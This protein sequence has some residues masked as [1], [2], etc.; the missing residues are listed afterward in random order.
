[1]RCRFA[2]AVVFVLLSLAATPARAQSGFVGAGAAVTAFRFAH[3]ANKSP[4][5][6]DTDISGNTRSWSVTAGA[7]VARRAVLQVEFSRAAELETVIEPVVFV[8][9]CPSCGQ[10]TT[11]ARFRAQELAIL[12]GFTGS[13]APRLSLTALGGVAFSAQRLH[14]LSVHVPLPPSPKPLPSESESSQYLIAPEFGLDAAIALTRHL[15]VVPRV[16]ISRPSGFVSYFGAM[17]VLTTT[18][19]VEARWYF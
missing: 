7:R 5:V 3:Q 8:L 10:T 16:R 18:G 15:R 11:T 6:S 12:A 19:G 2:V 17:H 4:S 14:V 9:P 13:P 1:M